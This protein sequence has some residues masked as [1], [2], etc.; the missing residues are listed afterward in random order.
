MG[1]RH[2]A[3][4]LRVGE[5]TVGA[6]QGAACLGPTCDFRLPSLLNQQREGS[7]SLPGLTG[8]VTG[9]GSTPPAGTQAGGAETSELSESPC[10][11]EAGR[12]LGGLLS[13]PVRGRETQPGRREALLPGTEQVWSPGWTPVR[14]CLMVSPVNE[15]Q[16]IIPHGLGSW[17]TREL[18][19]T[20]V[21]PW[22]FV[23]WQ[24]SQNKGP[25]LQP[26]QAEEEEVPFCHLS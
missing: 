20:G 16:A 14:V 15:K 17:A 21:R 9:M 12:E 8:G 18:T 7:V 22:D 24:A 3:R 2:L 13:L 11:V 10:S 23:P 6:R 25:G 5:E 4:G 26:E 19:P 1:D